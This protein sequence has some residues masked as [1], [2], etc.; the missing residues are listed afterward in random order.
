MA[1]FSELSPPDDPP[2]PADVDMVREEV[3][4]EIDGD[5][6]EAAE[7]AEGGETGETGE[8]ELPFEADPIIEDVPRRVTYIEYLKSPVI[9][10]LVGHG[11]DQALLTAHEALLAQSPWFVETC[12]KFSNEVA[13]STSLPSAFPPP[14]N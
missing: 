8:S 13:V 2:A 7:V 10:L 14:A 5:S 11:E 3:V 6:A 1:D 4:I 9:T 12:A